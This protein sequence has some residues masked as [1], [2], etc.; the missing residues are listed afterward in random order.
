MKLLIFTI[1]FSLN[2]YSQDWDF[3]RTYN[4]TE[5][6]DTIQHTYRPVMRKNGQLHP[7]I[8]VFFDKSTHS[9][10]MLDS[11]SMEYREF[12]IIA[13]EHKNG[14]FRYEV[15]GDMMISFSY[16]NGYHI[17]DEIAA[18]YVIRR[19]FKGPEKNQP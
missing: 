2:I 18:L 8:H 11:V 4:I 3:Y 14:K 7:I 10:I 9:I 1:F 16:E 6:Y 13:N 15:E 19:K 5:K 12:I 17:M